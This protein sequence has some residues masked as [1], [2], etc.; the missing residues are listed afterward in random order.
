MI[1]IRPKKLYTAQLPA[2][3]CTPEMRKNVSKLAKDKGVTLA[4]IQ[5]VAMHFFLSK[6]A[7]ENSNNDKND[8]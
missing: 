6:I 2:T 3:P 7:T 4:E 8:S 5:R 1:E